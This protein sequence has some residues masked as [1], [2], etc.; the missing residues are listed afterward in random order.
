MVHLFLNAMANVKRQTSSPQGNYSHVYPNLF[1]VISAICFLFLSSCS[2]LNHP[3]GGDTGQKS[4]EFSHGDIYTD[5][6]NLPHGYLVKVNT[7]VCDQADQRPLT[8]NDIVLRQTNQDTTLI[9][10][11]KVASFFNSRTTPV[12]HSTLH[13]YDQSPGDGSTLSSSQGSVINVINAPRD[14]ATDA[15]FNLS[16]YPS[17]YS[18]HVIPSTLSDMS[19]QQSLDLEAPFQVSQG[20][21]KGGKGG[22]GTPVLKKGTPVQGSP[23]QK[24]PGQVSQTHPQQKGKLG[25]PWQSKPL[26]TTKAQDPYQHKG[27]PHQKSK[28]QHQQVSQHTPHQNPEQDFDGPWLIPLNQN[29]EQANASHNEAYDGSQL[30]S[31]MGCQEQVIEAIS[32]LT[33][34]FR[35]VHPAE[36]LAPNYWG[37]FGEPRVFNT[38]DSTYFVYDKPICGADQWCNSQPTF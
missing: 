33:Q 14:G 22:K 38:A 9:D 34:R 35:P 26:P 27:T 3:M 2:G 18:Y 19:Q 31:S 25:D 23:S 21:K 7:S 29:Q 13:S 15:S 28:G 32:H 5:Y 10:E 8:K 17:D 24:G 4:G 16:S 6:Y 30:Y 12:A 20:G 37:Y 11:R 1:L 36:R